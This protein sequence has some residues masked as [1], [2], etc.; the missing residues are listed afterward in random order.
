MAS[1][2]PINKLEAVEALYLNSLFSAQARATNGVSVDFLP[3]T[4]NLK[5]IVA[6][7]QKKYPARRW[8]EKLCHRTLIRMRKAALLEKTEHGGN[9]IPVPNFNAD[10]DIEECVTEVHAKPQPKELDLTDDQ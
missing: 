6:E 10:D 9:K 8:T 3:Y 2:N 5:W 7:M 1:R 4:S